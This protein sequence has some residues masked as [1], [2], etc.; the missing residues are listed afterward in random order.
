MSVFDLLKA[1]VVCGGVAFLYF[2]YPILGQITAIAILSILWLSYA[3]KT[4]LRLRNR[5]MA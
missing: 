1:T 2:S 5:R 4:F 3:R